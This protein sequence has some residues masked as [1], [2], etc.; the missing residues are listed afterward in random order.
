MQVTAYPDATATAPERPAPRLRL[1]KGFA[2]VAG[3]VV[4]AALVL[5]VVLPVGTAYYV[6]TTAESNDLGRSDAIVVLGAAQYNGVPS[7]VLEA[8]LRHALNLWRAGVAPRIV[9]VG[10][11]QPT[12]DHTEAGAGQDWLLRHGVPSEAIIPIRQ[13]TDTLTSLTAVAQAATANGWETITV[14][15]D[16]AHMA[17][18]KAIAQRLGFRVRTSPTQGG[19]GSTVTD[20]YLVRETA[21]Y[22]AFEF[23]QQWSV[24]V[25][26]GS[27]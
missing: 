25:V 11:K 21:G 24:P 3:L 10:G 19:D 16:P 15:S 5:A 12:D 14:D 6:S 8:R 17:R 23:F 1:R 22:L 13:G 20:D 27:R 9:T 2:A 26:V 7:P 4:L 18:S